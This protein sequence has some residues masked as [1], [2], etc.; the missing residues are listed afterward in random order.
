MRIEHIRQSSLE[1]YHRFFKRN[2]YF[3]TTKF[4]CRFYNSLA[5]GLS[6]KN[7]Q[8][9]RPHGAGPPEA[10]GIM[11]LHRMHR[12]EAGPGFRK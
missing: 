7:E 5:Q 6:G 11:Q 12:L 1:Q 4:K 10:R 9:V 8:H 2:N 3:L